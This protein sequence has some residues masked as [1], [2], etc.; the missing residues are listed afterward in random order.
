MNLVEIALKEAEAYYNQYGTSLT[1]RGLF[2]ILVSKNVISNTV[3]AYKRL[4]DVLAKARYRGEFPWYLLR[5]STRKTIHMEKVTWYPTKPLSPDEIKTIIEYYINSYV[6]VQVNPW[7]DQPYRIFVIVEKEA[8][9]D[10]VSKF[11]SEVWEYGVREIRVIRGYDSATDVYLLAK[12]IS[13]MPS[14]QK[15]VVLQLGDFDPSGE[16]IV[17]DLRE[18]LKML[19]KRDDIIFEKVAVTI[20]QIIDLRLPA[21][22]ESLEEITKM[23]RDSRYKS[24]VEKIKDMA[25]ID[26]RVKKLVE[27][28]GSPEIRVELDALVALKPDEFKKIL[29]EAIERYFDREVYEKITKTKEEEL[30][31]KAEEI[32]K[33]SFESLKKLFKGD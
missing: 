8:L 4:S 17:R 9:G 6:N 23:R 19:S 24:Y 10:L 18:R 31:K 15:P 5:D 12:D 25:E 3:S 27:E 16:D 29:R 33:E 26:E 13:L 30:K 7:E 2:Y 14:D 28:Y 20:D 32:K 21:K 11:I 22:P 1:L